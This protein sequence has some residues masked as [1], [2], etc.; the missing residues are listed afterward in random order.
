VVKWNRIARVF[1]EPAKNALRSGIAAFVFFSIWLY[2]SR[3]FYGHYETDYG[4]GG[5]IAIATIACILGLGLAILSLF[6][7]FS[8][9][10][11]LLTIALAL[12]ALP[13]CFLA[14]FQLLEFI[15]DF[16]RF[17][18]NT[19]DWALLHCDDTSSVLS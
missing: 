7:K 17:L 2:N 14:F 12:L 6:E 3:L 9:K 10:R 8:G 11:M 13:I 5:L 18:D 4:P 16:D 19:F 15:D 1:K